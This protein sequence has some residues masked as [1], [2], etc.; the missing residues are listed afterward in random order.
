MAKLFKGLLLIIFLL[1]LI[2]AA[3]GFYVAS[4][5]GGLIKTGINDQAPAMLGVPVS[6]GAVDISLI[7]ATLSLKQLKIANPEGF[8]DA[9]AFELGRIEIDLDRESLQALLTSS[10]PVVVV[11]RI[12]IDGAEVNAEQIGTRTNLQVLKDKVTKATASTSS[13]S[14][15][16][17]ESTKT[18][19]VAIALFEFTNAKAMVSSDRLGDQAVDIP[20]LTLENIGTPEKGISIDSAAQAILQPLMK[21]VIAQVQKE[22]LG[23]VVN[24]EIDKALDK[25]L[26]DKASKYKGALKDLF[27]R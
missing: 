14:S 6:V 21:K 3:A 25:A 10:T 15:S 11:D 26:G 12:V 22:A 17:S 23:K 18:P 19:N 24:K 5:L 2:V 1:L 8:S 27:K 13:Q 20:N 9:N 4:N 16:S 7:D